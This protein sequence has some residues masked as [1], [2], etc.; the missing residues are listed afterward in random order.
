MTVGDDRAPRTPAGGLSRRRFLAAAG[1][2]ALVGCSSG[3]RSRRSAAPRP[4]AATGPGTPLRIGVITPVTGPYAAVGQIVSASLVAAA[5]H[6][7][8]DLSRSYKGYRPVFVTADAPLTPDDG[9]RAY[10][11]LAASHVDAVLWCGAQGLVE[12]LAD[13]VADLRPVIAVGTD[14]H[15]RVLDDP[16]VPDLT[17]KD[18]AG[19]PV[20]QT[21]LADYGAV[22]LL[23]EYAASDRGFRR[24][25][26]VYSATASPS[27]IT[28]FDKVCARHGVASVAAAGFDSSAGPPDLAVT[29]AHLEQTRP[30]A[31]V[32]VG[33]AL[34]AAALVGAL[35]ASGARYVDTPTA[36]SGRFAPMVLGVPAATGTAL[37]ARTAGLHAAKGTVGASTLGAVVGLPD[38]PL[39]GWIRRFAS[40]YNG[41]I[42]Q[43]GEDGPADAAAAI[44]SAAATARSTA[45]ADIV[46]ALESGLV[47]RFSTAVGFSFGPDRHLSSSLPADACVQSLEYTPE[48]RY[49]LGQDWVDVFPSGYR[50]PDL[51]VDFTDARNQQGQPEVM[52]KVAARRYGLSAA[53]QDGDTARIAAF[54]AVH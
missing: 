11:T 12:S 20:F 49:A 26:L 44:M 46:A 33:S 3:R 38:S 10:A 50:C 52:A 22:D 24:L 18:A 23:T 29:V 17:T 48:R 2:A 45:G 31:I 1:T 37:F 43:G 15:T 5:G 30:E 40:G 28:A 41:G 6:I 9:R 19:F 51:L 53:Y 36:R 34:D 35:D 13:V 25:A 32:V 54:R 14:L 8:A 21:S 4:P 7:D 16:R 39:R 47:T 27:A 42:P